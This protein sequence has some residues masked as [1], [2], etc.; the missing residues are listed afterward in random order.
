[1]FDGQPL[2]LDIYED[3]NGR[4][5]CEAWLLG[6][7]DLATRNRI[8]TRLAFGAGYRLYFAFAGARIVLLLCGGDKSSQ[9]TDVAQAYKFWKN[10]QQR[11]RL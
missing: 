5:P 4:R 10:Y 2:E 6:L 8:D 11:N 7:R 1:M 3:E 9:Q